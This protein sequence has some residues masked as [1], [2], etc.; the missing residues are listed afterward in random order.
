LLAFWQSSASA[1][2][3]NSREQA[4][5]ESFREQGAIGVDGSDCITSEKQ[6]KQPAPDGGD[7]PN[8]PDSTSD[9]DGTFDGLSADDFSRTDHPTTL[10]SVS[11]VDSA[12]EH[13][14]HGV[15]V[16]L[17]TVQCFYSLHEH[18]RERAPTGWNYKI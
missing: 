16:P 11:D 3:T 10:L 9:D 8:L 15:L 7:S 14:P 4:N 1:T 13:T 6:E 12:I 5:S 17:L 2:P 18:I